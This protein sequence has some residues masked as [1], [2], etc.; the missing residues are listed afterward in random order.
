MIGDKRASVTADERG[1]TGVTADDFFSRFPRLQPF[2]LQ[3]LRAAITEQ[4]MT[5]SGEP[6]HVHPSLFPIL[7]LLSRLQRPAL[8]SQVSP[9]A[10]VR[11]LACALFYFCVFD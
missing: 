2:L 6:T 8:L 4:P 10:A 3:Q 11:I 5:E 9:N 1:G 7:L